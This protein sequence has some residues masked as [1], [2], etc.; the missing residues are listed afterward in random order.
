MDGNYEWQKFSANKRIEG[1]RRQ[2][3]AHRQAKQ[4]GAAGKE[5]RLAVG[6]VGFAFAV[7]IALLVIGFMLTGCQF[8][9]VPKAAAKSDGSSETGM[10][11]RIRFHDQLWADKEARSAIPAKAGSGSQ[12]Q[13]GMSMAERIRFQDARDQLRAGS[14]TSRAELAS[15]NI[16][17]GRSMADRIRF[18]DT[19]DQLWA[20][21]A[22]HAGTK[23]QN[24]RSMADR[25]RFQDKLDQQR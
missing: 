12:P 13:T 21:S 6:K 8:G 14:E 22:G 10:A 11:E 17:K 18:Q 25:I 5:N 7:G 23:I 15:V 19:R 16:Q 1:Y 3:D 9:A 4:N 24:D 20:H 2:A